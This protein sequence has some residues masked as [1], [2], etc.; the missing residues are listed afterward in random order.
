MSKPSAIVQRRG[1]RW[2]VGAARGDE[3]CVGPPVQRRR[4][5]EPAACLEQHAEV[6]LHARGS[7]VA[8]REAVLSQHQRPAVCA[9]GAGEVAG[10]AA[11]AAKPDED[12]DVSEKAQAEQG[13]SSRSRV[14]L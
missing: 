7:D 8:A 13:G 6:V 2:M 14:S 9:L 10:S 4:L 3:R 11:P 1:H 12:L 5:L